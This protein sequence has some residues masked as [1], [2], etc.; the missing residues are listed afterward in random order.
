MKKIT[1]VVLMVCV[2]C[3]PLFLAANSGIDQSRSSPTYGSSPASPWVEVGTL[4]A[5]VN[6]PT[7]NER[8]CTTVDPNTSLVVWKI[9]EWATRAMVKFETDSDSDTHTIEMMAST[10][11]SGKQ[12]TKQGLRVTDDY[13]YV[14]QLGLTGG[15]QIARNSNVYVDSIDVNAEGVLGDITAYDYGN[16]RVCTIEFDTKGCKQIAFIRTSESS[17]ALRIYVRWW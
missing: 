10:G 7:V 17:A 3:V 13:M 4:T 16:N 2:A 6:F 8:D 12:Y 5:D 14:G 9:P 1:V 15:T 11:L